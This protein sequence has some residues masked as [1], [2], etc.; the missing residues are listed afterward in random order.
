MEEKSNP[1]KPK[2]RIYSSFEEA[3]RSEA[4][5]AANKSPLTGLKE[6]VDLILRVYGVTQESLKARRKKLHINIIAP[7]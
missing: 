2:L 6:T 7:K 4:A 1:C 5:D 3:A